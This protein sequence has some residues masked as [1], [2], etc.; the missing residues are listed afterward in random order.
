[1]ICSCGIFL[2]L[3]LIVLSTIKIS[4]LQNGLRHGDYQRYRQYCSRRVR[5]LRICLKITGSKHHYKSKSIEPIQVNDPRFL[6]IPLFNAERGW[7][8][9]MQLKDEMSNENTRVRFHLLRRLSKAAYHAKLLETLCSKRAD[10]RT[11]LQAEAYAAWLIASVEFEREH[12]SEA[13]NHFLHAQT[14]YQHLGTSGVGSELQTIC[15]E[16]VAQLHDSIRF[17][18][19]MLR[20]KKQQKSTTDKSATEEDL[21]SL[22]STSGGMLQGK[23]EALKKEKMEKEA[24]ALDTIQW[25]GKTIPVSNEK[26]R[27]CFVTAKESASELQRLLQHATDMTDITPEEQEKQ[28][29]QLYQNIF[30]AYE[31]ALKM[32][33]DDLT[34]V[35]LE[36]HKQNL[37]ALQQY[38]SWNKLEFIT[39]RNILLTEELNKKIKQQE[40]PGY[41]VPTGQK[42]SKPD[43]LVLM[44]EKLISNFNDALEITQTSKNTENMNIIQ[45]KLT[46]YQALRVYYL[47]ESYRRISKYTDAYA[48]YLRSYELGKTA[49]IALNQLLK[50]TNVATTTSNLSTLTS[51]PNLAQSLTAL[52]TDS[53]CNKN[54]VHAQLILDTAEKARSITSGVKSL[55][56]EENKKKNQN[57]I[58]TL[59]ERLDEY[60]TGDASNAFRII[61]FPPAFQI[62]PAKPILF[63]LAFNSIEF[64]DISSRIPKQT[65]TATKPATAPQ[66]TKAAPTTK[67]TPAAATKPSTPA[68]GTAKTGGTKSAATPEKKE[69]KPAGFFGRLWGAGK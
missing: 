19:Y 42:R 48:L 14:V 33:K 64:P 68:T 13:L 3:L 50:S 21:M 57:V 44:Y 10:T 65:T 47:G 66:P 25:Q 8:Y 61:D 62:A 2:L 40:I 6:S 34:E 16:R 26:L 30:V 43:E 20:D 53:E 23:L 58:P 15:E 29:Q 31:D 7:A 9:A 24:K 41:I 35:K 55:G 39:L 32:I 1:M 45:A 46:A 49:Q 28:R 52:L 38:C 18:N 37:I 59:L 51:I 4:Q 67:A 60:T 5:R 11:Q 12:H 54:L 69:D 22:S 17:C 63:D 56:L 27:L 36:T